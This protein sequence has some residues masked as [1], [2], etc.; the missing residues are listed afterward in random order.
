MVVIVVAY[1]CCWVEVFV[2]AEDTTL[3]IS[4]ACSVTSGNAAAVVDDAG[5]CDCP[6]VISIPPASKSFIR[7][8]CSWSCF[9]LS[10]GTEAPS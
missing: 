9:W 7:W 3:T 5:G 2:A 8:C 1:C 4:G 6:G 10:C